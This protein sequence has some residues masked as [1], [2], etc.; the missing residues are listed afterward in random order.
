MSILK[1]YVATSVEAN[2]GVPPVGTT[3]RGYES[4]VDD[5]RRST[6]Y[7]E[8]GGKRE[9]RPGLLSGRRRK[10]DRGATGRIEAILLTKG[11]GLR[12]Q[13][14]LG[15]STA[16]SNVSGN[17]VPLERIDVTAGGASYDA[18]T[19]TVAFT[20]GAG[21]GA[22]ATVVVVAGAITAITLTNRGSG[23]TSEPNVTIA[24]TGAGAG[25]AADA[26]L[27]PMAYR[28]LFDADADGPN[29]SYA[30]NVARADTGGDMRYFQYAGCVVTGMSVSVEQ[31]GELLLSMDY[32][33]QSEEVLI[34]VP[35]SPAYPA[36]TDMYI[37]EDCKVSIDGAQVSS[38]SS[39]SV[40]IDTMLDVERWFIKGS[41]KK[42]QPIRNGVPTFEGTL[43]GEFAGLAEY[44]RFV[45][46]DIVPIVFEATGPEPIVTVG[47]IDFYPM[48]KMTFPA[49]QYSG[50]TPESTLDSVSTIEIP[51]VALADSSNEIC[52]VEYISSDAAF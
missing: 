26:V 19:T 17:T 43:M 32:D 48:F 20:G 8:G 22:T 46:G 51:F 24:D 40:D 3:P 2:Y 52:S 7:I 29:G 27:A 38:F 28:S 15:G 4:M 34:N 44:A 25:A 50:S 35:T 45:N 6:E 33:V 39:F 18:A 10:I 49:C 16:P 47:G 36:D 14:A 23:Y 21:A 5:F 13:H 41:D 1:Q 37:Y 11:E 9:G 30:V 12:L 31:G 42:S